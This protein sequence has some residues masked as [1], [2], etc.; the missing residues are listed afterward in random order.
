M[1]DT[2][3]RRA[4]APAFELAGRRVWVAGH[5]G[6]VGSALC[7]RLAREPCTV[8]TVD[9]RELDLMVQ[10]AVTDWIVRER[11][12]LIFVAAARVGGILANAANPATFLYENLLIATNIISAAHRAGTEKLVFLASSCI[13]PKFAPQPIPEEALLTGAL[14]PTNESY[15]IAKIAGMKL[16]EAYNREHG[17]RFI[18]A[19][20][21]NLYG[22]NDNFDPGTSHVLP[23]LIRR[24]HEAHLTGAPSVTIWGS[25]TPLREFLHVDDLADACVF[26]ARHYEAPGHVNVGPGTEISIAGLARLVGEIVGYGGEFVFDTSKPDGTPRKLLDCTRMQAL[27]WKP[28]VG[29]R[30]GVAAAYREWLGRQEAPGPR[31]IPSRQPAF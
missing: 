31:H 30:Q 25:G 28:S 26:L 24:I 5:R 11:P 3:E 1:T 18:T 15:A 9:R 21:P 8:L 4:G 22:P 29:L 20:P 17:R 16:A 23:A 10:P 7:R 27:G 6:M 14:E 12:D 19:M 2:F 13:Y